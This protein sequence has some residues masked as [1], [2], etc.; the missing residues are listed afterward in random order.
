MTVRAAV[1]A[2]F[3]CDKQRDASI[4]DQ[5][6]ECGKY[7]DAQGYEVVA[8]YC[9]YAM[10]GRSDDR[11]QF[12][13]MIE[14]ARTGAFSVI[15]VWKLDRFARNMT[16]Q[17]YYEHILQKAGVAIES[18]QERISGNGIEA[19]N[20]KALTAL[21]A[22]LRSQQSAVD[23]VRGMLGKA[24]QCQYLGVPM[25]GYSHDGDRITL[26]PAE[27]PLVAKAHEDYLAGKSIK[28]IASWLAERGARTTTGK[29]PGYTFVYG[30]LKNERYAGVYIWGREK[31]EKGRVKRDRNGNPVPLVRVEGGMPAIVTK[32]TKAAVY[33]KLAFHKRSSARADYLLAGKLVCTKCGN[34]LHG[35]CGTSSSGATY[36]YYACRSRGRTCF[37]SLPKAKTEETIA[38][39]VRWTLTSPTA[40][41]AIMAGQRAYAEM[42]ADRSAVKAVRKELADIA[43]QR[44]NLVRA[45]EEGMEYRLIEGRMRDLSEREGALKLRMDELERDCCTVNEDTLAGF[46]DAISKGYL[47]DRQILNTF[48]AKGYVYEG[49]VAAILN[50]GDENVSQYEVDAAINEKLEQGKPV[51]V[52]KFWLPGDN[53]NRTVQILIFERSFGVLVAL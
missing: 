27:A 29:L 3:S 16:D 9:D 1:Y 37:G 42:R 10:S 21:F 53:E 40:R 28:A 18:T 15:L 35:H 31:D 7:A 6:Y 24:R 19:T 23:T 36:F 30:I 2:R 46:L 50:F 4:D 48:M 11:P 25:F 51:R 38:S 8:S 39:A 45:V 22:Q 33:D 13:R 14:D 17:Y 41:Q 20:N 5:L 26:N 44:D 32:Q 43:R 47:T 34:R 52:S 49:F 12:L